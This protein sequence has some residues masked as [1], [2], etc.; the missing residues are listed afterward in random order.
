MNFHLEEVSYEKSVSNRSLVCLFLMMVS[1]C[2]A[3]EPTKIRVLMMLRSREGL[4]EMV[5]D[6]ES[7]HPD[8]KVEEIT[9]SPEKDYE[10]KSSWS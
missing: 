1:P 3:A 9:Y 4:P 5:A 7:K 10:T 8:I 2:L 6:F